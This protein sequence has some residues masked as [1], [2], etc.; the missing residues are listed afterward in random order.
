MS[1]IGL[2]RRGDD[3]YSWAIL[4]GA[5]TQSARFRVCLTGLS[6]MFTGS[7]ML[8]APLPR[9]VACEFSTGSES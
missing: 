2:T 8:V 3:A 1:G 6:D 4:G 5:A 7:Q 9:R